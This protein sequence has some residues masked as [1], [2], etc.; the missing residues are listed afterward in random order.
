L[1][2]SLIYALLLAGICLIVFAPAYTAGITNWDDQAYL[3][4]P[5]SRH[6]SIH[7]F[8]DFVFGSFHPLTIFSFAIQQQ[9]FGT[10]ASMLHTT[11][12][13]LHAV[14]VV[15][16]FFLLQALSAPEFGSFAGALLWAIHPLR[17]E[18]VVWIAERK[19]VLCTLFFIAALLAYVRRRLPLTYLFFVLALLS[20]GMAVSLPLAMLCIDYLQRRKAYAEKVPFFVLSLA[21]G[22]VGYVGQRGPGA[23]MDMPGFLFT[24]IEKLFLCCQTLLFY[25]GKIL[26]PVRLCAIYTYPKSMTVVEWISPLFVIAIVLFVALT[27][28]VTRVLAFAFAFFVVTIGIVLPAVSW[29]HTIAADRFTYIPSIGFAYAI[30]VITRPKAWPLIAAIAAIFGVASFER[31]KVW[32][33][34]LSL[35][36]SVIQ[37][38][39]GIAQAWNGHAVALATDGDFAGAARDLDRSVALDPC[40]VTGTGNRIILAEKFGDKAVAAALRDKLAKCRK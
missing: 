25:L 4:A 32:D 20:K 36:T 22:I 11:D 2:R 35:W 28:R 16:L 10:S 33:S 38:D 15:L 39:P 30:A 40:Y 6:V 8:T 17:V 31:S 18:S 3:R 1:R 14:S 9:L 19:D 23:A 7:T 37:A 27:T 12:V 5:Q 26:L 24:P 29:S 34:S 13:V 21:F